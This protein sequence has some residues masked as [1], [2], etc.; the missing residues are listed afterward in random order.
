VID[1]G[2][3]ASLREL[4]AEDASILF[5]AV[6]RDREHFDRW[7]RWTP[8]LRT[9]ADAAALL[10]ELPPKGG[11]HLGLFAG[12]TLQGGV[13]CWKIQPHHRAAEVGYWLADAAQG[14]GLATRAASA[15]V[16][17]L[18]RDKG[19]HRIEMLTA[20]ANLRSRAVCERLGFRLESTRRG[21]HR[22]PGG[23]NDHLVY[24]RLAS[25]VVPPD[26][27]RRLL[28]ADEFRALLERLGAAWRARQYAAAASCFAEGVTYGDPTRYSL[29]GRAALRGFFEDDEDKEQH[30]D[31]HTIVFDPAQQVGAAE[32][33]Y[34]GTHRYHG[35]VIVR[36]ANGLIAHWR[37]HQ[38]VD[39]G[40][41]W[42]E[43]T[44]GLS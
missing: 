18:F 8:S 2:G 29:H 41:A 17:L 15:M 13:I 39:D 24:A 9:E 44:G 10:E 26:P 37:E 23:F 28:T 38:H 3:G 36:V 22:F 16:E 33:T 34:E 27:P 43:F 25:D 35:A 7:L 30:V 31:W 20:E 21:S 4:T 32:Y 12:G 6:E 19:V 11:F 42:E 14:K 1:L 5:A 40:R